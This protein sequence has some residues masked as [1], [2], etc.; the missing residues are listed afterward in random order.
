MV[1]LLDDDGGLGHVSG[2]DNEAKL[3]IQRI[4]V[5]ANVV[6]AGLQLAEGEANGEVIGVLKS[7]VIDGRVRENAKGREKLGYGRG[8]TG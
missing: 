4:G 1:D 6:V 7:G 2:C 3:L 8:G 5:N